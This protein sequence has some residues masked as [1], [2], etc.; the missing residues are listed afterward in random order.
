MI[1]QHNIREK[2]Q[3]SRILWWA[4]AAR[5]NILPMELARRRE[6]V[7]PAHWKAES[8]QQVAITF[9]YETPIVALPEASAPDLRTNHS[10]SPPKPK[11]LQGGGDGMIFTQGSITAGW[12]SSAEGQTG[13][14]A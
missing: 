6:I 8:S 4:E 9:V 3:H 10:S 5:E 1:S 2:L 12:V 13:W 14:R 7:R 11:Y